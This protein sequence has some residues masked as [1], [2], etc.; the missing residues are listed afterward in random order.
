MTYPRSQVVGA[1]MKTSKTEEPVK[2]LRGRPRS[3]NKDEA[4]DA[5]VLVFWEKGYD[6]ASIEDLTLAMGINRPSLY[7][8]FGNKREF[9]LRAIDR[10]AETH[11]NRAFSAFRLEPDNRTAI[12]R[13]FQASIECALADGT[14]RGCLINN[15]A[16]DAAESDLEL[17]AKLTDMFTRTDQAIARRLAANQDNNESTAHPP[18]ELARM[19][20]SVTHSIMTRARAGADHDELTGLAGSFMAVLFPTPPTQPTRHD[21]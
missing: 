8:A 19:A 16:T 2:R 9:F 17:R 3:F 1:N 14:P 5:A 20:H 12:E 21:A 7:A 6:G 13:F 18:E 10:Y 15:V 4:L 11:G